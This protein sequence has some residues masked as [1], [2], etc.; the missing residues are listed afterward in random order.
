MSYGVW[1]AGWG[2]RWARELAIGSWQLTTH[3]VAVGR[4]IGIW[5]LIWGFVSASIEAESVDLTTFFS[6]KNLFER[7]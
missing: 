4:L 7:S 1:V 3:Y 5:Y 6:G 2:L